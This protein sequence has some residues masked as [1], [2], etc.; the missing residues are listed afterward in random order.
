MKKISKKILGYFMT[1]VARGILW[2]AKPYIIAVTGS[3]GKTSVKDAIYCVLKDTQSVRKSEKFF[4]DEIATQ[5]TIVGVSVGARNPFRW[6]YAIFFGAWKII[7]PGK[8]PKTLV[9]EIG[10]VKPGDTK[11]LSKW[12]RPN[13][14]V[15][16]RLPEV[17]AHIEFFP[18]LDS[19]I[20]EKLSLARALRKDGTLVLNADDKRVIAFKEELKSRTTTYGV[21]GESD[22]RGSNIQLFE[23][24]LTG[25]SKS[26]GGGI[27]F[28]VD[29][30]GK[31]FPVILNNIYAES[32]VSVALAPLAVAKTLDVNMV[33]AIS[34]LS[35]Y[36]TPP[37]RVR[38]L[39]GI[40]KSTIIDDTYNSS[41]TA[42]D[43]GLRMLK[44]VKFG[45]RKIA[46]LGDM[47][48]LG[49]HTDDEH[50]KIGELAYECAD[51]LIAVG[52]RGKNIA[53]GA[54]DKGM[55]PENIFEVDDSI[56]AGE[57]LKEKIEPE[58]VIFVK[59]SQAMRMEKAVKIVMGEPEKA[60]ELL[61]RQ[62][63]E[64]S[65]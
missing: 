3:V 2:R 39:N 13:I 61:V 59:G 17:P 53:K 29:F 23:N 24:N 11:K 16:T 49:R 65:M 32:Y 50:R 57:L 12:L 55:N 14:V 21:S 20:E 48:E 9:L 56:K 35:K 62:E 19:L 1:L 60:S 42:C 58:D 26:K 34:S 28:K 38:F 41:P 37:G 36:V 5:L 31:S 25:E 33:D 18:T 63:S 52:L 47:L 64:W 27:T 51:I 30:D 22:I 44:A 10:A 8:Y 45:K 6:L 54:S 4:N 43:A 15:L 40:N 46:V 7:V